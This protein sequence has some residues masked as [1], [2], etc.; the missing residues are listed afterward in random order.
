[1]SKSVNVYSMQGEDK[2]KVTLSQKVFDGTINHAVIYQA[3]VMYEANLRQGSAATKTRGEVS[4]GGKKPWRQKG[5]GRA[6]VGSIRSPIWR[7]GGVVFG[8]HPRDYSYSLPRKVKDLALKSALN[9]K[10][11]AN[12]LIVVDKLSILTAKTKEI[13]NLFKALSL[14]LNALILLED[15]DSNISIASRNISKV[16]IKT[17]NNVNA[18]DVLLRQR[19]I[20]TKNALKKIAERIGKKDEERIPDNK[21]SSANGKRDTAKAA[22]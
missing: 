19:V 1:M 15:T 22:E 14:P 11:N 8:P 17:A 16:N 6:R 20:T 3:K 10:L 9:A 7:G 4:G 2:G 5:T 12:E 18:Y 21:K 13:S